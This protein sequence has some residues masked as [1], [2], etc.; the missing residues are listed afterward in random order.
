[1]LR[2]AARFHLATIRSSL[3]TMTSDSEPPV[4]SVFLR[5]G[6]ARARWDNQEWRCAVG[7]G[8]VA[9]KQREGDGITPVGRWPRSEEHTSELQSLMRI[10]YAVFCLKKKNKTKTK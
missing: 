1:M 6:E 3:P 9:E 5:D 8:G 10:A 7:R 4:L 2:G